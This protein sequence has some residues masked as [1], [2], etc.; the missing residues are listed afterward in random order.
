MGKIYDDQDTGFI[1]YIFTNDHSPPHVHV[2]KKRKA[3]RQDKGILKITIGDCEHPP[4]I[5]KVYRKLGQEE[6]KQA[7]Q[8]IADRQEQFLEEWQKYHGKA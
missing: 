2:Y 5:D 8:I 3:N 6:M 1:F 4:I 7:W